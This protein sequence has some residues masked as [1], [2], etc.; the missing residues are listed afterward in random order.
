MRKLFVVIACLITFSAFAKGEVPEPYIKPS[1]EAMLNKT[2]STILTRPGRCELEVANQSG[3]GVYVDFFY[4]ISGNEK[5]VTNFY[6]APDYSAYL[7]LSQNGICDY[8][9]RAVTLIHTIDNP[10]LYIYQGFGHIDQVLYVRSTAV[11]ELSV[12][13]N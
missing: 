7:P 12:K 11:N 6:V 1:S 5:I 9:N 10:S 8:S 3:R 2:K 4:V 13:T